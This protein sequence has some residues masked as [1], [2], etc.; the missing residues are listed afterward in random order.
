MILEESGVLGE[1]NISEFPLYFIPLADDLLSLEFDDC[2]SDLYLVSSTARKPEPWLITGSV[3]I[4]LVLSYR[5]K[6]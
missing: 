1:V 3:K 6:P 2:F 4:Q 5:Q